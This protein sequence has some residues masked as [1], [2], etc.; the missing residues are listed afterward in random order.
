[1][2]RRFVSALLLVLVASATSQALAAAPRD[3][4][5][6]EKI[7]QA[8]NQHYLATEFDQAEALLLGTIQACAD[9]CSPN[10]KARAWMYVGIIRGSAKD[11]QAGA[12]EAFKEALALDPAVTLDAAL[13]TP[14][15]KET[16]SKV[17]PSAAA[18][19]PAPSTPAPTATSPAATPPAAP[20]SGGAMQC[21]PLVHEVET[22]RPLPLSCTAPAATASGLV[23]FQEVNG[24]NWSSVPMRKQGSMLQAMVPCTAT[25]VAGKLNLYVQ[26]QDAQGKVVDAMGSATAP[27]EFNLVPQSSQPPPSLPGESAPAR[28]QEDVCATAPPDFPGCEK[29]G[30]KEWGDSCA[31]NDECKSMLCKAGICDSCSSDGDCAAGSC[32]EG[33][34]TAAGT[35][36]TPSRGKKLWLGVHVAGDIALV[37]GKDVCS[38]DSQ[39]NRGFACYY[40]GT[41]TPYV[42]AAPFPGQL[43]KISSGLVYG[44]TRFLVSV[45]YA[46]TDKILLGGR[47]GYALGGGPK[48]W[49]GRAFL[50]LHAEAR[51]AYSFKPVEAFLRPYVHVGGG[52]AQIDAKVRV[53]LYDCAGAN[54][55]NPAFNDCKAGIGFP[56]G[57]QGRYMDVYRK[58]GQGFAT[59]GGGV[60]LRLSDRITAQ[61]NLNAM[62]MLPIVGLVIEP[63]LG[64]VTGL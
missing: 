51:V 21:T 27:V 39:I 58:M 11:N 32:V 56:A 64:V 52:V 5:A 36:A 43:D 18:P 9:K 63:S 34:C 20:P 8:I 26:A 57:S 35:K 46:L 25:A 22:R 23:Y 12:L 50:P 2:Y 48:T 37:G 1:V 15:T 7:D 45:D 49:D 4:A 60:L 53:G 54:N 47:L 28:C 42:Y 31:T 61:A 62:I 29:H 59:A 14:A 30:T 40:E 33:S 44:T 17:K 55:N 13:A 10:V 3:K 24:A 41:N 38:P 16:F 19:T 6:N